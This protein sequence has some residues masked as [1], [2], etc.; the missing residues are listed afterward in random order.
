MDEPH[1]TTDLGGIAIIGMAGRFPGAQTPDELWHNICRGMESIAFLSDDEMDPSIDTALLKKLDYIRARGLFADIDTFDITFFGMTPREA[2]IMDPQQR[3]FMEI[4]WEALEHAGYAPD[5]YAGLIGVFA[6]T[7][8]N[9]YFVNHVLTNPAVVET[10]GMHQAELAN[11]PDYVASRISFKFNLRGPSVSVYTGCSTSLV[12]VCH[13]CD[14]LLSYQSDMAI[15]GGIHIPC[16]PRS[17]YL[18]QVG[19]M[20]SSDGHTRPFDARAQGTV[21]SCGAGAI[22]LKRLDEA[23]RERDCIYAIIRGTAV[24]NDGSDKISFTAPSVLGQSEV[25]AMAQAAS[26]CDPDNITYVEAH[27]TGTLLGDPIEVEALTRAF[28]AKTARKNFCALGSIKANIGHL[29][30]AA[31]VAGLIKAALALHYKMLPPSINFERP[32]PKIDLENSPFYINRQLTPWRCNGHRLQAG[33]SSFGV[34]GTN[35]HV[36]LEEAPPQAPGSD[37]GQWH[38][39]PLSART[40]PALQMAIAQMA[41]FLQNRPDCNLADVAYT[42]QTGRSCF[43]HRVAAVCRDT[44]EAPDTLKNPESRG[45]FFSSDALADRDVVF[46]FSGQ[47]SQYPN[48]G[49]DLYASE[50][51]FRREI[52][53]CAEILIRHLSLDLRTVLYPEP[54]AIEQSAELLRQTFITQPAL[55]AMEYALAKLWMS[56]GIRP[57]VVVGHSI[58]EYVAACLSGIVT[59]DDALNIVA[60]RGRLIQ[61]CAAGAMLAVFMPEP[62]VLALID[63]GLFLSV[64]NGP[65]LCVLSGTHAAIQQLEETLAVRGISGRRLQTSHAFHSPMMQPALAGFAEHLRQFSLSPPQI[66]VI[67]NVTGRVL[68]A[69]EATDP[70]YWCNHLISTVRFSDCLVTI[71]QKP[72]RVLL[73]VGPGNSLATLA[74][75]HPAAGDGHIILSSARHPHEDISDRACLLRALGRLWLAGIGPDWHTLHAS[76]QRCRIALPTYPFER[77][78]YWIPPGTSACGNQ[79]VAHSGAAEPFPSESNSAQRT[80]QRDVAGVQE[81]VEAVLA[82]VLKKMLGYKHVSIHDNFFELGGNSLMAVRL[83]AQIER[84]YAKRLPLATLYEAPTIKQLADII[85]RETYEAS[86]N[87]LVVIQPNGQRPPFFWM[88]AEGGNVLECQTLAKLLGNDQPFYGLQAQGLEGTEVVAPSII[89]MAAHNIRE[90]KTVQQSGPYYL[91]GYC[92]GGLVAFEMAQQL[93]NAGEDV[94]FLVLISTSTGD[95]LRSLKPGL[96]ISR[97]LWYKILDRIELEMDNISFMTAK[98]KF[99]YMLDRTIRILNAIQFKL[100][101]VLDLLFAH[102]QIEYRWHSRAY[103]LHKSVDLSDD[104]YMSYRPKPLE[105]ELYLFRVSKKRHELTVDPV[106]G[107][108]GLAVK[109]LHVF[110]VHG[111]HKNIMKEPNVRGVARILKKLLVAKQDP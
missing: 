57:S 65:A 43:N 67:S 54:D 108:E 23:V 59:L 88:H 21:F 9:S 74:L 22:V 87:S 69:S 4:S 49:R 48:M 62:E 46:M 33:V 103:I 10:V 41:E 72:R 63:E 70:S 110:E 34:G 26:G 83:F 27:G 73:E 28:R 44:V 68:S 15:A 50:I 42:L 51:C 78:R 47:G 91:G 90:I 106:L 5:R 36:I 93:Q 75:Q 13:A 39:L 80:N 45:I 95:H 100:E 1:K 29:D 111:F 76:G 7:S 77:K 24:N 3:K 20:F 107:W 16:P 109:G 84:R 38:L 37:P 66:P 11:A 92:L 53:R 97:L 18:Y 60:A 32:N 61:E 85:N 58:G 25:I 2:E 6:G 31:G 30:A 79:S 104:S 82:H 98:A 64:I 101:H 55:F 105:N 17:G 81:T 35:A 102:L 8:F 71:L 86:W 40:A 99:L 14:S 19:E 12:A 52:D 56:W 96:H 89:E 94:A